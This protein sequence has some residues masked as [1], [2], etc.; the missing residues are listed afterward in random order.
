MQSFPIN[1]VIP[2]QCSHSREGGNLSKKWVPAFE[3]TTNFNTYRHLN[4]PGSILGLQIEFEQKTFSFF[5]ELS[6]L[7][8]FQYRLQ[9][10]F[11]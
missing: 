4:N 7:C 8:V 6:V 9:G 1:A 5:L 3:G 11:S 2:N 10:L